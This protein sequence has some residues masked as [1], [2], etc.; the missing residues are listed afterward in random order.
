MINKGEYTPEFN[1][2]MFFLSSS[3]KYL[4]LLVNNNNDYRLEC[5]TRHPHKTLSNR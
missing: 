5:I 2:E 1:K 4:R 3:G